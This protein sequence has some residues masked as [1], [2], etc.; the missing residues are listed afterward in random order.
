MPRSD[1]LTFDF[2]SEA[3]AGL[4]VDRIAL[5]L[6]DVT[7]IREGCRVIVT[8]EDA[9]VDEVRRLA[10]VSYGSWSRRS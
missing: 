7:A 4:F 2:E 8:A 3:L 1:P 5:Y 9:Q 6:K 10:R